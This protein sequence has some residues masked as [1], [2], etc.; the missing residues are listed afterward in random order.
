MFKAQFVTLTVD[1]DDQL[2]ADLR[3]TFATE[4]DATDGAAAVDDALHMLCAGL[5]RMLKDLNRLERAPKATALLEDVQAALRAA[6]AEQKG[7]TVEVEAAVAV[8]PEATPAALVEAVEKV[9]KAA[10]RMR[11]ATT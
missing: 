6:K 2:K 5:V 4:A 1:L 10:K 9:R 3:V 8:D 11:S 7:N